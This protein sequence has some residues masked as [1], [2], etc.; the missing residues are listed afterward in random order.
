[1]IDWTSA[2]APDVEPPLGQRDVD[3]LEPVLQQRSPAAPSVSPGELGFFLKDVLNLCTVV[4]FVLFH[5]C[6]PE[7]FILMWPIIKMFV[8]FIFGSTLFFKYII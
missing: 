6:F 1:M 5:C 2:A 3:W 8:L 7:V 4:R